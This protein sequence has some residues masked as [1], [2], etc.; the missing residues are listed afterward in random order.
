MNIKEEEGKMFIRFYDFLPEKIVFNILMIKKAGKSF[1]NKLISTDLYPYTYEE[2]TEIAKSSG[3]RINE[4]LGNIQ[5]AD[6]DPA[7]SENIIL[8]LK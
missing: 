8:F 5:F 7:T 2:I 6:Y 4:K 1:D 3:F